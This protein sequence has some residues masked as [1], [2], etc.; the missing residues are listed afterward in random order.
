[1]HDSAL[2]HMILCSS[3]LYVDV[4]KGNLESQE[5]LYHKV[6]AI[7]EVN[8]RLQHGPD[9]SNAI[10]GTVSYLA[11]IEVK[12]SC[13]VAGY[14]SDSAKFVLGNQ[15]MWLIHMKGLVQMIELRGGFDILSRGLQKKTCM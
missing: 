1:M 13:H 12:P 6:E 8:R 15:E 14:N 7:H 9:M 4:Q 10:I 11:K 3:A 2:F 5:A